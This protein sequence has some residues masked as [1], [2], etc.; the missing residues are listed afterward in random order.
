MA[1]QGGP[2]LSSLCI[3]LSGYDVATQLWRDGYVGYSEMLADQFYDMGT[4]LPAALGL[5]ASQR[6]PPLSELAARLALLPV[7]D[8]V[9][10]VC[11]DLRRDRVRHS[12]SR[13]LHPLSSRILTVELSRTRS[14]VANR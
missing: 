5:S 12:P 8:Y 10:V 4:E 11:V 9:E 7:P 2:S 3:E 6:L 1:A 14:K 13:S